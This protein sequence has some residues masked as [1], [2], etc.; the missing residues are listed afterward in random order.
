MTAKV[1][2]SPQAFTVVDE[3]GK[4]I[5]AGNNFTFYVGFAQPDT[6][7]EELTGQS[8]ECITLSV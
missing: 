7:S 4:R 2:I 5:S 6:R 3:D 1:L 8:S